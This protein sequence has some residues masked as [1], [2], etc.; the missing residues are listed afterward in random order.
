MSSIDEEPIY[1][2]P[3]DEKYLLLMRIS[4][5]SPRAA[6]LEAWVEVEAS[7]HEASERLEI[8]PKRRFPIR[9]VVIDS[10]NT[11]RYSKSVLPLFESLRELRN[12]ASHDPEFIPTRRQTR[13]YLQ[14]AIELA[15]TFRNPLSTT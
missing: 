12:E 14:I 1:P 4:E 7:I 9:R 6:L 8:S 11:G 13:R 2:G 3:Y 5:E 15:I 10:I